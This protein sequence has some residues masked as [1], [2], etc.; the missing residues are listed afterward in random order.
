MRTRK[1]TAYAATLIVMAIINLQG[2]I[3]SPRWE[4]IRSVDA[5]R[6]FGGGMLI[7]AAVVTLVTYFRNKPK[8]MA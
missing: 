8:Q 7:G 2:V 3:S 5:L 1:P 6:L 4:Q